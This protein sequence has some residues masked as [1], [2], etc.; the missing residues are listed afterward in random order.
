LRW[1]HTPDPVF[2]F[3]PRPGSNDLGP[4]G[5][6]QSLMIDTLGRRYVAYLRKTPHRVMS[7]S[8][9]FVNWTQ[10]RVC[11]EAENGE[12]SNNVYNH[13]GFVY[14]DRYLGFL[15]YF[16]RYLRDP[17]LTIQLLT[18]RDG[19]RWQRTRAEKP[20]IGSGSAGDVDR[21]TIMITGAP[22][23]RV[24]DRLHIYYR[25]MANRHT[26][27]EG[28]D[29]TLEGGGICLATLRADG[30]AS[31]ESGYEGGSV[32][33]KPFL[34]QGS[35]LRVNAKANFGQIT[36]EVLDDKRNPIAG[37]TREECAPA[38]ADSTDQHI[39][40]AK[41]SISSLRGKPIRLRFEV[42]NARLYSYRS[43]G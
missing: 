43:S 20:L 22:P 6:A 2:R 1:T 21:Y 16:V 23:I 7:V 12:L 34:F 40:W 38:R 8:T 31:V 17:R 35:S 26:P 3:H 42:R 41:S 18:S 25:A 37:F 13:V 19:E 36:V 33:T 4:I 28:K 29:T 32:T 15:T 10:P 24:G 14:G 39:Q 9:D 11:L 5:D 30:F 27:Y